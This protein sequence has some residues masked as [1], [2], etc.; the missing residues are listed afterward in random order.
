[1]IRSYKQGTI[2]ETLYICEG[3]KK[4]DKMCLEGLPAV[5]IM[6]IHNFAMSGEMPGQFELLIKRCGVVNVVFL[7]DSDWQ[8]ISVK[9]GKPVDQRPRLF[10]KAV[11][12][13]HDYF[14]AYHHSGIELRLY[15]GHGKD[16]VHKGIDD[17]LVYG[18][19]GKEKELVEDLEKA[20]QDREGEGQYV[21]VYDITEMSNYR[22]KE[23]WHLHSQPAFINHHKEKLK[24]LREFQIGNLRRRY[25][26]DTDEFELAQ[27]LLPHEQYWKKQ[28]LEDSKGRTYDKYYFSYVN[29]RHFFAEPRVLDCMNMIEINFA[30]CR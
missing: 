19:K 25:N 26:V 9:D 12:K 8:D 2:I 30:M 14:Y 28:E 7:L 3:E 16:P 17:L 5:G 13:F 4:A 29:I 27:K 11:L 24:E 20:R 6:G 15:L 10:F 1:M 22:L 18:L 23:F 21:N